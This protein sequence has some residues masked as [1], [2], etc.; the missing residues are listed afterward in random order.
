MRQITDKGMQAK[1]IDKDQW[2]SKPFERGA[3]VLLGRITP[4][5]DRRFYYRYTDAHGKR[6]TMPI[7][8]YHP[9]GGVYGLDLP[10]AAAK[11][12]A[13][14]TL[15]QSG[16]KN[17]QEH[18]KEQAEVKV[19]ERERSLREAKEA[20]ILAALEEQRRV[21]IRDLFE[22]W[23]ATR[24][25]PHERADGKREGRKDGGKYV[26]DQFERHVFPAIGPVA[27]QEIKKK[28]ILQIIDTIRL[29]G[30]LRT[31]NT[32]LADLKQMLSFAAER[33]IIPVNP[34]SSLS[35]HAAG[36]KDVERDRVLTAEEIDAL[37]KQ[38]PQAN[39]TK[40]NEHAIW[41]IL[42][43]CCRV[44]ELMAARWDDVDITQKKWFMPVT[45]NQRTH[46]VHLSEFSLSHFKA[47]E[48]LKELDADGVT[49]PWVFSNA[50]R[51][52]H[53]DIKSFGKQIADRQRTP[54]KK[55]KGRTTRTA[56]LILA[57]GRWTAHDLRRTGATQMAKLGFSTDVIDECL[58]HK[59]QSKMARVYI[60]D[61]REQEQARAFDALGNRLTEITTEDSSQNNVLQLHGAA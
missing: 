14:V 9:K 16:V 36:G 30:K 56:S 32:V 12:R 2:F 37:H 57:G 54:D 22:S 47:L 20:E 34:I 60:H 35:K 7:G 15:H 3:G 8:N 61:R 26:R 6:T 59:I 24:L 43:T 46:T 17:V 39:L 45:K 40:R 4:N 51:T 29:K 5:G 53:V 33:D 10:A 44:G 19:R 31:C 55:I 21:S 50:M 58:N 52:G 28:D 48:Q 23:A 41:L 18:L 49:L 25:A 42:A 38:L 1:P 11:A 13:L 27:A